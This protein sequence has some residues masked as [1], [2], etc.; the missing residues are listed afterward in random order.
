M[1]LI[2][3][4]VRVP[5]LNNWLRCGKILC[6]NNSGNK[7]FLRIIFYS[8]KQTWEYCIPSLTSSPGIIKGNLKGIQFYFKNLL[9]ARYNKE[10]TYGVMVV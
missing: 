1:S 10:E 8:L 4:N 3:E 2:H 7:M 5:P 6:K 9:P